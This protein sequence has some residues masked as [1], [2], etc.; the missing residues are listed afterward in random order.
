MSKEMG[1]II[2]GLLVVLIPHL[3]VPGSW[4]TVLLSIAGVVVATLGFLLRGE[5]L[6]HTRESGFAKPG[7]SFVESAGHTT[8]HDQQEIV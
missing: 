5:V 2:F 1:V 4:Q 6:S 3:G 7:H 8:R